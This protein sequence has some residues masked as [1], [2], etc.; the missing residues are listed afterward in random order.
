MSKKTPIT[1]AR[2]DGI[3][4]EIMDATLDILTAAGAALDIEEIEIGKA[5][6]ERGIMNGIEPKSWDSLHRTKVFLK[7]PITT[8]QGGGFKSLNVTVRKALGL[9]ANVRPCVAY[10]PYVKTHFPEMDLV[11]VRENEEDLY[12]GI[13]HRQ[14]QDVIQSLK[15]ISRPGSER[16]VRYAFEYARANGR[17]KVTCM[18]KDNIMKMADGLFHAVFDEIG[19]EYPDIQ[20]EFYIIDIGTARIASRPGAFDVIVTENL[21]GD[22]ISDVAVEVT[23][24]VGLGGSCNIGTDFGMFE[25]VHG[26]APDI[27]GKGI[28]NPSGLLLGAILMLN[29]IGQNPIATKVHNAWYKTIEDGIHTGDI[30]D[31]DFSKQKV[32]TADFAKAVI[33]R[34]GQNPKKFGT[35]DYGQGSGK[36]LVLPPLKTVPKEKKELVG[37]DIFLDWQGK[38]E[39]LAAK[40]KPALVKGLDLSVISNRGVKVWPDGQP[41]T[42]CSD[43]WCVRFTGKGVSH[44]L[45][46]Q[47]LANLEKAGVD[48]IKLENLYTFNGKYG[49]TVAQGE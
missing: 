7:A 43:H 15:L 10:H 4:P 42:F 5:V 2:G 35:V 18:A 32:G 28:A 8:P 29:H 49:F 13:E 1:V 33:D 9:F 30:Y 24:S 41:G 27:A 37:A 21:Y 44:V 17:K 23:G 3:G 47:Q 19:K 25:A 31:S 11:I 36:G 40:L 20:Q 39:D 45:V 26:S 38:P 46:L 34:L 6:Y 22:I 48:F 14:T 16:I 12:A